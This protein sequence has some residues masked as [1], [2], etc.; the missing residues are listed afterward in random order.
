MNDVMSD[1]AVKT[2]KEL[3]CRYQWLSNRLPDMDEHSG[4]DLQ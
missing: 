3:S 4:P 2:H 1:K